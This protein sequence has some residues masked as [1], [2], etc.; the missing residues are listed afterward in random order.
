MAIKSPTDTNAA[1]MAF[2]ETKS[3][4]LVLA[5]HSKPLPPGAEMLQQLPRSFEKEKAET[6]TPGTNDRGSYGSCAA[7]CPLRCR[8]LLMK[9]RE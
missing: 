8:W 9:P 5:L 3:S 2:A 6:Q 1:T 7:S 4:S